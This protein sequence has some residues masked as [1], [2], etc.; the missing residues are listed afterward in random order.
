MRKKL[1]SHSLAKKKIVHY[2]TMESQKRANAAYLIAS[3]AIIYLNLTPE[4]AFSPLVGG[5]SPPFVPF[6]DA[7][8]GVSIYTITIMG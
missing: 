5:S 1:K 4:E 3:Y 8:L 2:T 6:R 7:S